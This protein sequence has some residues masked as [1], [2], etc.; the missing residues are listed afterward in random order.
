M[1]G[2]WGGEGRG[3]RGGM[4]II[5][6]YMVLKTSLRSQEFWSKQAWNISALGTDRE[7]SGTHTALAIPQRHH[8]CRSHDDSFQKFRI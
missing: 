5:L 8:E 6:L 1:E 7:S 3:E 4:Y 2:G